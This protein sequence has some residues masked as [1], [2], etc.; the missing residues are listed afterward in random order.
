VSADSLD[1]PGDG[2][3]EGRAAAWLIL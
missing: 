2:V 3:V 1:Q